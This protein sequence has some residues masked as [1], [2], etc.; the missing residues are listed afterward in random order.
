MANR[1]DA[2]FVE[3]RQKFVERNVTGPP[4]RNHELAQILFAGSADQ[5]M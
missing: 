2:H 1:K 3:L 4:E 5:R